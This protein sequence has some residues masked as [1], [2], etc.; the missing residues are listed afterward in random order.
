MPEE[1]RVVRNGDGCHIL[2]LPF[3][4]MDRNVDERKENSKDLNGMT[5]AMERYAFGALLVLF[6]ALTAKDLF[7]NESAVKDP[8][9]DSGEGLL[10]KKEIPRTNFR[11]F[12]TGY[13]RVFEE[14]S[15]ILR[16]KY[17]HLA[18]I[19]DNYP[20]P[21]YK[22]RVAHFLSF[23]KLVLIGLVLS[24][25]NPFTYFA[26]ET[27]SLWIWLTQH[28]IYGCL[29]VFFISNMI[30]GNLMS[31]GAF[32]IYLNAEDPI[33]DL[34]LRFDCD[35]KNR[36]LLQSDVLRELLTEG[37]LFDCLMEREISF[38]GW[39]TLLG[40]RHLTNVFCEL[41]E[42]NVAEE[43]EIVLVDECLLLRKLKSTMIH[44]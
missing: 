18:L 22:L 17:P 44:F 33:E 38:F 15:V 32:E 27:P 24:N 10:K 16:E 7:F 28:K 34:F 36:S 42:E 12:N 35:R 37:F 13:R 9:Q 30:E 43:L 29:M 8:N 1:V 31:T 11:H 19:G 41:V 39:P 2:P 3:V 25:I 20:P 14:Y 40:H 4:V 26:I 6:L 23:A 21:A 5:R